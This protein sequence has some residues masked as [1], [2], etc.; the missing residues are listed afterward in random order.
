MRSELFPHNSILAWADQAWKAW[1]MFVGI[2]VGSLLVLGTCLLRHGVPALLWLAALPA[3]ACQ[4]QAMQTTVL[5]YDDFGPS[6]MAHEMLGQHWWQWA[7]TG[8]SDPDM[9]FD[10]HVVVYR[11]ASLKKVHHRYPVKPEA[12]QDYRYLRYDVAIKYLDRHIAENAIPALTETLRATRRK[13]LA[14]IPSG[15][16]GGACTSLA[17]ASASGVARRPTRRSSEQPAA[18]A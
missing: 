17:P 2:L 16:R 6:A 12:R 7:A 10:V 1:M 9:T 11:N 18:A 8:G 15:V 13:L 5:R 3:M 4:P 14:A